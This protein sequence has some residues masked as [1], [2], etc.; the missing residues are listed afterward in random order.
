MLSTLEVRWF[1]KGKI[2]EDMQ[3]WFRNLE[4]DLSEQK[5]RTDFYLRM[6]DNDG[7][8]IKLREGRIEIKKR[9][10]NFGKLRLDSGLAGIFESWEKWG[11][12]VAD[13]SMDHEN[14]AD[15]NYWIAVRKQRLLRKYDLA[16]NNI[17]PISPESIVNEAFNLELSTIVLFDQTCWSL[18]LEAYG[19][20]NL[21]PEVFKRMSNFLLQDVPVFPLKDAISCGYPQ[22]MNEISY[23]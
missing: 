21:D 8:G 3:A 4:G 5:V 18:N 17:R 6:N 22:W 16:G 1:K 11:F 23:R 20:N 15:P 12:N 9:K 2:P 13:S 10:Q 7:L 19:G 14:I